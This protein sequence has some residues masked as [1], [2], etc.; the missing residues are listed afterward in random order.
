[1]CGFLSFAVFLS[2]MNLD[3]SSYSFDASKIKTQKCLISLSNGVLFLLVPEM[4]EPM[5]VFLQ[6]ET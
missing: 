2:S 6:V 1:V 5:A 3:I 4:Q